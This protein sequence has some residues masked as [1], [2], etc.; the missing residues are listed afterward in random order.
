M[1]DKKHTLHRHCNYA[2]MPTGKMC[3]TI[4]FCNLYSG[5]NVKVVVIEKAH[6]NKLMQIDLRLTKKMTAV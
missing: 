5:S 3:V 6:S 1:N 4:S 2:C